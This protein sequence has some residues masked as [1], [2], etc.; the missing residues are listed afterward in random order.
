[1]CVCAVCICVC[2]PSPNT[3]TQ[4]GGKNTQVEPEHTLLD[5]LERVKNA[6]QVKVHERTKNVCESKQYLQVL[7]CFLFVC[8]EKNSSFTERGKN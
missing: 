7:F 4:V 3:T 2:V 1:M 5:G 8:K 6:S